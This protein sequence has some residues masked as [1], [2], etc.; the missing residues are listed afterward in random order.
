MP[1]YYD[2]LVCTLFQFLNLYVLEPHFVAVVLKEDVTFLE[3]AEVRPVTILAISHQGVEH[4]RV[5]VVL[6]D[7]Y[8]V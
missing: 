3:V 8:P 7:L 1:I 2:V 5:A 4:L 6:Q